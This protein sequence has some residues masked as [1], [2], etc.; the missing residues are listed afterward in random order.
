[1][2]QLLIN[3]LYIMSKCIEGFHTSAYPSVLIA[4]KFQVM[5]QIR[6]IEFI[7]YIARKNGI[8]YLCQQ[9]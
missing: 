6:I 7:D 9:N 3:K 1:M 8:N 4:I 2:V 5:S